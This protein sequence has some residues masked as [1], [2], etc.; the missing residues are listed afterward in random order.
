MSRQITDTY[1]TGAIVD[2]G[3]PVFLG[4]GNFPALVPENN[5]LFLGITILGQPNLTLT[6]GDQLEGDN[7]V[8]M[9]ANYR[10]NMENSLS[11]LIFLEKPVFDAW[12]LCD[13]V[14]SKIP[15]V[16][17]WCNINF[18]DWIK[19]NSHSEKVAK[20]GLNTYT[21]FTTSCSKFIQHLMS[22]KV[23]NLD[24][25]DEVYKCMLLAPN[26]NLKSNDAGSA[27]ENNLE[28]EE[29]NV[30]GEGFGNDEGLEEE[31]VVLEQAE[32]LAK[33]DKRKK[34]DPNEK[35]SRSS[36]RVFV[37]GTYSK[38]LSKAAETNTQ[39]PRLDNFVM[40]Q[41]GSKRKGTTAKV[42]KNKEP[43]KTTAEKKQRGPRKQPDQPTTPADP[44][45]SVIVI[46]NTP[47][48]LQTPTRNA[49][50][51]DDS[52]TF[53]KFMSQ[54]DKVLEYQNKFAGFLFG[55]SERYASG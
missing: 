20:N 17:E 3:T 27:E 50:V 40:P 22:K 14:D 23:G 49:S 45:K 10:P 19:D 39:D 24:E 53:D 8:F 43:P 30:D 32:L 9:A 25:E 4:Y 11:L 41:R 51:E 16:E 1:L 48:N 37:K 18:S 54:Q 44:V 42:Q 2:C 6:F 55:Y 36:N 47:A 46:Q 5:G 13:E 21:D 28:N 12:F 26:F 33:A 34:R 7:L 15:T 38:G 31:I 29:G 52:K 35:G